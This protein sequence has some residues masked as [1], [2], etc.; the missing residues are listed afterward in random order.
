MSLVFA[1]GTLS[2][3]LNEG[4]EDLAAQHW[5]EVAA[6]KDAIPLDPDYDAYRMME[7]K[8]LFRS[9]LARK[10]GHL[11]GYNAFFT[12]P[13]PHYRTTMHA[14]NDVIFVD[15]DHRGVG[16]LLIRDAERRL[17]GL[18]PMVKIMYHAKTQVIV[19]KGTV[20]DL[21]AHM[22]YTHVEDVYSKIVRA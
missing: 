9:I 5:D 22:G 21:L 13:S 2:E 19:G 14:V 18:A 11:I 20:G 17:L 16:G 1:W 3:A 6:D 15:K 7:K 10:D 12:A 8:G 4:F